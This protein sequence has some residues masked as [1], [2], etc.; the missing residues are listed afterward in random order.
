MTNDSRRGR[1]LGRSALLITSLIW[2][3]SFFILKNTL[4]SVPTLYVLAFRFCGAAVLLG[5]C[6]LKELKKIDKQYLMGGIAMGLILFAAYVVQTYGLAMT[7]P[8][9]NAFLTATY[10]IIAPLLGWAIWK[11]KPDRY[12]IIAA[13]LSIVGIGFV[14]LTDDLSINTG[15]ALTLCSGF[16][17]AL[18]IIVIE[19]Y[20][21]GRSALLLTMLQFAVAGVLAAAFAFITTPVPTHIPGSAILSAVY[22]C[23][24][25]SALCNLLQTF[26]Q[27]HTPA[28]EASVLMTLESVFGALFSGIFYHERFTFRLILGFTL[29]FFGVLLSETKLSFLRKKGREKPEN[30]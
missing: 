16:F 27:K 9:K 18:Q 10:C 21:P 24:F 23:V 28:A 2:G 26:G 14:S 6:A 30:S 1:L 11:H 25:C 15:D 13:I 5:L 4:D 20:A 3:T 8:G 29:I 7:T 22:L 12:N 17:F 19:R